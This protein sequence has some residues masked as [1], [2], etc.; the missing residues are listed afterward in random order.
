MS[1]VH[2]NHA[3]SIANIMRSMM[4]LSSMK[5]MFMLCVCVCGFLSLTCV[6]LHHF[7]N[8]K[9]E[10]DWKSMEQ[11]ILVYEWANWMRLVVAYSSFYDYR[12]ES[13]LQEW[14]AMNVY[15]LTRCGLLL[16]FVW[17]TVFL[18]LR[19]DKKRQIIFKARV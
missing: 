3:L 8:H 5:C 9:W 2:F 11:V 13:W 12:H 10:Y 14:T 7:D 19:T 17:N 1:C 16:L 15:H 4:K 18:L 6:P